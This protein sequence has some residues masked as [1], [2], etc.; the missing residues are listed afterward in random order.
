MTSAQVTSHGEMP[1]D[2][3]TFL[4]GSGPAIAA[5]QDLTFTVTGLPH[6]AGWPRWTALSLAAIILGAGVWMAVSRGGDASTS[7]TRRKTL[8]GRRDKLFADLVRLEEQHRAGQ[9]DE[10]RYASRRQEL[11]GQ[12]E[13]IYSELDHD[14]AA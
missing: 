9:L 11:V 5:G 4:V 7:D 8:Q 2:G 10:R 3:K 14:R 6:R 13:R 12:L 1:A